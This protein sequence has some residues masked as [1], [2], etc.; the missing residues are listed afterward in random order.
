MRYI[1][2]KRNHACEEKDFNYNYTCIVIIITKTVLQLQICFE[3]QLD[4][5]FP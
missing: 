2:H 4:H 1:V 3:L 5:N